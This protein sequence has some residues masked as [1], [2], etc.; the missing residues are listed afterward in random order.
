MSVSRVLSW[1][2]IYLGRLLPDDSSDYPERDGPPPVF[3]YQSCTGWGLHGR[4]VA[5]PPVSSYLAFPALP[6]PCGTWA[7]SFCCTFP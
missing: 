7:V 4:P 3:H 5:R 1:T 6:F 2:I